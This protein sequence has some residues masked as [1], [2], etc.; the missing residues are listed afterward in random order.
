MSSNGRRSRSLRRQRPLV[1]ERDAGAAL[2]RQLLGALL[3]QLNEEQLLERKP[4]RPAIASAI[5]DGRCT[6]RSASPIPGVLRRR[7]NVRRQ[8]LRDE[9]QQRVE[10]R[11]DDRANEL[12]RQPFGR[13]IDREHAPLRRRAVV[14]VAE[15]DE[16][17]RLELSAVEESD[18][19]RDE[20]DVA[21]VDRAIEKRLA[22]P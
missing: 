18:V 6:M 5:D 15:I 2:A 11:F 1:L 13:R 14:V 17:A 3:Q 19:A 12:E 21:L 8:I 22:G 10:M 16:L 4:R 20:Q 7:E 9:R